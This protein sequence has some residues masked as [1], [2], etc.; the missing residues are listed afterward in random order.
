MA[1]TLKM[2]KQ[3]V[4]SDWKDD[5]DVDYA[6]YGG[7]EKMERE[8]IRPESTDMDPESINKIKRFQEEI[9]IKGLRKIIRKQKLAA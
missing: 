9:G 5:V 6:I 8:Y 3:L 1:E 2:P 7:S 4:D